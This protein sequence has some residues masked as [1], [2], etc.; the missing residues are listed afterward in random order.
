M[1]N[2]SRKALAQLTVIFNACL[3]LTYFPSQWKQALVLAFKKP[4]KDKL[5][6]QN[7]RP[8]SLLSTMG[9]L[10]EKMILNRIQEHDRQ[11][12]QLTPEQF[13]FTAGHSTVQQLARLTNHISNN[14]NINKSTAMLL[15]DIEKAFDTVWHQALVT[16]PAGYGLPTYIVKFVASY[17]SNRSFKVR[18]NNSYSIVKMVLA[19]VPQGS[20]LGPVLS[21]YYINDIPKHENTQLALFADDTAIYASS[22]N[23]NLAMKYLQ[24]HVD[25][26]EPYFNEWKIKINVRKTELVVFTRRPTKTTPNPLHMDNVEIKPKV[27]AKYL[28]VIL[29]SRLTFK[30]HISH[31]CKKANA[32]IAMMY[33]LINKKSHVNLKN[34][35]LI[36]KMIVSPIMLYAAPIWGS[37]CKTHIDKLQRIQNRVMKIIADSDL[38]KTREDV[39]KNSNIQDVITTITTMT[40]NLFTIKLTERKLLSDLGKF[41]KDTA[42]FKIRYKLPHHLII[43]Q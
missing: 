31:A 9:K 16:K 6:P 18:V 3:Q 39:A 35:I 10:L 29:D 37:A 28:G 15:L 1:K 38:T 2:L 27:E 24:R 14:F 43:N 4:G 41:N 34:K 7:Y 5:F 30:S 33:T 12:K 13:G 17:L 21:L 11:Q 19:G 36:Y 42:P 26:L 23:V 32:V 20:I 22:W 8:I 40:K 25:L